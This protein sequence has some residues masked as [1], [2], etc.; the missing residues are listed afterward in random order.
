MYPISFVSLLRRFWW[1]ENGMRRWTRWSVVFPRWRYQLR[2]LRCYW[3]V[4]VGQGRVSTI[5]KRDTP[6]REKGSI[7][8]HNKRLRDNPFLDLSTP[9]P[10]KSFAGVA[11]IGNIRVA[12]HTWRWIDIQKCLRG[13]PFLDPSDTYLAIVSLV[14]QTTGIYP[15][16]KE[17][18]NAKV[19]AW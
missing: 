14:C 17:D 8:I 5:D 2:S 13:N 11:D 12:R 15:P 1:G 10:G 3:D 6:P 9:V 18:R 19:P 4:G 16:G 7:Y